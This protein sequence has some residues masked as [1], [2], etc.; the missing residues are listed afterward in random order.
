MFESVGVRVSTFEHVGDHSCSIAG[1]RWCSSI[2]VRAY[3]CSIVDARDVRECG[4]IN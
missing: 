3:S 2:D 1:D 4:L